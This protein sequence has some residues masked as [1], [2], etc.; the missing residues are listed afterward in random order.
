MTRSGNNFGG[1]VVLV[2]LCSPILL[3][4]LSLD[5]NAAFIREAENREPASFPVVQAAG[6]VLDTQTWDGIS[7]WLRERVPFRG[8]LIGLKRWIE[9]ELLDERRLG[10]VDRGE[11][12]WLFLVDSYG[13]HW[14][15]PKQDVAAAMA[16]TDGFLARNAEADSNFRMLIAP[17]KHAIYPE[18]LTDD[19][20]RDL[21]LIQEDRDRLR[22]R[23]SQGDDARIIDLHSAMLLEKSESEHELYFRDDTHQSW[24]GGAVMARAIVDSLQPGLWEN[25]S[26]V[27]AETIRHPGDLRTLAGLNSYPVRT[28][29]VLVTQRP[30]IE[31]QKV[32]FDGRIYEDFSV[33]EDHPHSW[34][35]PVRST[36]ASDGQTEL[37]P[38][39][40][41]I[42]HD[43]C[44]GW[45][46]RPLIR[47]YFEDLTFMHYSDATPESLSQALQEYDT[48]VL[49]VVERLAPATLIR[50]LAEPDP[51]AAS[52]SWGRDDSMPVWS[53][54]DLEP[55][56]LYPADGVEATLADGKIDLTSVAA[57]SAVVFHGL[58]LSADHRQ[59]ARIQLESPGLGEA[60][61]FWSSDSQ[62]MSIDRS[63]A[64]SIRGGLNEFHLDLTPDEPITKV[65]FEPGAGAGS[66][67]IKSIEI[68]QIAD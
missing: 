40:T 13:G 19:G 52:L 55:E 39:R 64:A 60:R 59:V 58:D 42:L 56:K 67:V 33:V 45:I 26:A 50:L 21:A 65:M 61:I 15:E 18:H 11:D 6:D 23:L 5:R 43:S 44:I 24:Y 34:Q 31:L 17:D 48:V 4:P 28:E 68:R 7:A 66:Y 37:I 62:E 1:L 25:S 3:L 8:D 38:G 49:E 32:E 63:S 47:P 22:A 2:L 12:G 35:Y 51:D 46:A 14:L 53:L 30:G 36:Y 16:N 41:L 29:Q 27:P 10:V 54:Q 57:S 20:R 9:V